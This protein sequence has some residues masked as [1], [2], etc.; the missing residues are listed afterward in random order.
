MSNLM[1]RYAELI[2]GRLTCWD[3]VVIAGSLPDL[4]HKDGVYAYMRQHGVE[5]GDLELHFKKLNLEIRATAEDLASRAGLQIDYIR[6]SNFRKEDRIKE[7]VR[8]RGD[9]PGLV[10]VFAAIEACAAWR[11]RR[12]HSDG[13]EFIY[14][15]QGKCLHYY[16][17]FIDA[18]FGLCYFRVATFAPFRLQF[19][20]NGHS[21]LAN[22]LRN[23]GIGFELVDNAFLQIDDWDRAQELARELNAEYLHSY[24]DRLA[25]RC[26]PF[27]DRFRSSY[28]WSVWQIELATDLVFTSAEDLH[29]IYDHLVRTATC[30]VKADQVAEFLGR[31]LDARFP[32]EIGT[33][34]HTRVQGT[35]VKHSMGKAA[36]KMYDKLGRVLRIETTASDVT[37]FTHRREVEHRDGSRSVKT[38]KVRKSIY[39]LPILLT[40]MAA[41]NERYLAFISALDDPTDGVRR[42]PNLAAPVQQK[43][44]S[45]RGFNLCSTPD[46]QIL[47]AL[48]RGESSLQG[49]RNKHL[50]ARLKMTSRQVST[51]IRRLRFHSIL[52]KAPR[53]YR[54]YLTRVGQLVVAAALRVRHEVLV[55]ALAGGHL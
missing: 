37:F 54:Y 32:D 2:A 39:S 41:A 22:T 17:Y 35:R 48:G 34:F 36:I 12:R 53:A 1:D 16:F 24:L 45:W 20:F 40:L 42:L 31:R 19:Y 38:A 55:P 3:R 51:I 21:W 29:P 23:A 25:A 52:R 11:V 14:S 18:E 6:K 43:G 28:R 27:M 50:R 7:I 26:L 10:H 44:R 8:E 15:R 13:G 46:H 49:L 47:L 30:S 33:H 9:H 4:V 5:V